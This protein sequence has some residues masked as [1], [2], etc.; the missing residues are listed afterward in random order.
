MKTTF[1]KFPFPDFDADP[2]FDSFTACVEESDKATWMLRLRD[3]I[4]VKKPTSL[5]FTGTQLT[6]AGSWE[7]FI[8][9]LGK[10]ISLPYGP[11]ETTALINM[12]DGDFL[13]LEIPYALNTNAIQP[14]L[15]ASQLPPADL[16][17]FV[18]G[19]RSGGSLILRQFEVI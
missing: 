11:D 5:T 13:Y 8:G 6:W 7:V 10:R 16:T 1:N 2:W 19:V 14:L 3:S 12:A 15:V 17:A 9:L 4:L 18:L